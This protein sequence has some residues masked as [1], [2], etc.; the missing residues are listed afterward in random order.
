LHLAAVI[1]FSPEAMLALAAPASF[2]SSG[3][4]IAIIAPPRPWERT[5]VFGRK[6]YLGTAV[7]LLG[8]LA[9]S[10]SSVV[11]LDFIGARAPLPDWA[12]GVAGCKWP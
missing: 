5:E 4:G 12:L 7:S 3:A 1:G 6:V 2:I 10:L 9:L 8:A 11:I